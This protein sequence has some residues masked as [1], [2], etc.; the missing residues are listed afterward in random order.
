MY[1]IVKISLL[2]FMK[3]MYLFL[4]VADAGEKATGCLLHERRE[5]LER[6]KKKR[7]RNFLTEKQLAVLERSFHSQP[8]LTDSHKSLLARKL[9]LSEDEIKAWFQNRKKKC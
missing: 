3:K 5:K 7:K 9:H 1:Y 6:P 8:S 2:Q 4:S